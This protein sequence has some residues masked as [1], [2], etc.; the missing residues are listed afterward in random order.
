MTFKQNKEE[1]IA[2]RHDEL[3]HIFFKTV[4]IYLSFHFLPAQITGS[5]KD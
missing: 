3:T 5:Q 1:V 2:L 4:Q